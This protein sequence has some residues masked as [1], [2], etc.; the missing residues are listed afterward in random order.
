[1]EHCS[2]WAV[3]RLMR[4]SGAQVAKRLQWR[5]EILI[6]LATLL[7]MLWPLAVNGRPFYA[8]DSASYL[9]GGAFGFHTGLLMV[10]RWWQ[11]LSGATPAASGSSP[12]SVVAGAIAGAG[13]ARSIIYSLFTYVVRFPGRLC[14]AWR[15]HRP[16]PWCGS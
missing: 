4:E 11:S 5:A 13:G 2:P 9:R 15:W 14:S 16:L 1:M 10:Q 8:A 7:L 12:E 6:F 3:Q